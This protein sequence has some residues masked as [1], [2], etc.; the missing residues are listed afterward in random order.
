M[1]KPLFM[2]AGGKTKLID[3][4]YGPLLPDRFDKYHEPFFGAGAM[5]VWAHKKNPNAKF[6]IND[7]NH[8]IVKV[9]QTIRDD[10]TGFINIVDGFEAKYLALDPPR[11]KDK[12]S[13]K[14]VWVDHPAGMKDADLEK[15][16][17]LPRNKYDW[18]SIY[19]EKQT[20][21][22][23]FFK[24]RQTY[25]QDYKEWSKTEEAATLYFLMKTAFNGVWQLGKDDYGRFNTPC[26]LMR[27]VDSIYEKD[28][29]I[30]WHRALQ[31]C[32]ITSNDF[33]DTINDVGGGSYVFLD[34]P[35][36]S[37]SETEKTFAD[38]GTELGDEFQEKVLDF[39]HQTYNRGA[40]SL[41]SNRDWG[42]NFF[43]N[44]NK[45]CEIV[46]FD[47]TYTVGRKK[48]QDGDTHTATKAKEILMIGKK[49]E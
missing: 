46:Y 15:K 21:R 14:T 19:A 26:G 32:D 47:V 17:K 22:T 41:L 29:V 40:Y 33:A 8:D 49:L 4:H 45:D 30:E 42:D 3:N 18:H 16:Y 36:R 10:V 35:Y 6:Y 25:Q 9:Y 27:H 37:A 43:E 13:D 28:N 31:N 1:M 23:F 44:R 38:Y 39:F 5:F 34:P 2:W 20:R 7:I 24:A 12:S 48:K 11:V